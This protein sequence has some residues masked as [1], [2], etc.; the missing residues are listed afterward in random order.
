MKSVLGGIKHFSYK[1]YKHI[2]YFMSLSSEH[3]ATNELEVSD[4]TN[5]GVSGH[6]PASWS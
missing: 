5:A 4:T 3:R 6:A 2:V 1:F